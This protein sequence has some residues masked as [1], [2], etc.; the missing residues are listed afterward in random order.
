MKCMCKR[1]VEA[2]LDLVIESM[3]RPMGESDD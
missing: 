1:I 2:M 3:I